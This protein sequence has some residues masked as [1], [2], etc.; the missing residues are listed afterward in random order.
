MT[1]SLPNI[2]RDNPHYLSRISE[3][4]GM[5]ESA[6]SIEKAAYNSDLPNFQK[7][8]R[9]IETKKTYCKVIVRII[10]R[11][12]KLNNINWNDDQLFTLAID[13]IERCPDWNIADTI[14]FL[15]F[16]R[17][18]PKNIKDLRI[19]QNF[20]PADLMRMIPFYNEEL[21]IIHERRRHQSVHE[22]NLPIKA[23]TTFS[24]IKCNHCDY[25]N[26]AVS[27]EEY[28]SSIG[29]P[30]PKC[31]QIL[32]DNS[33]IKKLGFETVVNRIA[34]NLETGVKPKTVIEKARLQHDMKKDMEEF[35]K[36]TWLKE[37]EKRELDRRISEGA[38][39]IGSDTENS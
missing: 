9:D 39:K 6:W 30:C 3:E 36:P 26:D 37:K 19:W 5:V 15:K 21:A 11:F 4:L 27:L 17:Q 14:C 13:V 25:S 32:Q 24:G 34:E 2:Q 22:Q 35:H 33:V 8:N 18:N 7:A 31:G 23:I 20:A 10:D 12:L 1:D 29:S 38:N 28:K 16:I